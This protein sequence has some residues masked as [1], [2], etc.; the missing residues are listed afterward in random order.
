[1]LD[2]KEGNVVSSLLSRVNSPKDLKS[3]STAELESLAEEIRE[4]ILHNVGATGGHLA[5]S[6]GVVELT[7]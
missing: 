6:L 5:P 3:M 7:L 4:F 1:M 2:R